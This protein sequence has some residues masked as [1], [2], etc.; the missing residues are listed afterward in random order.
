MRKKIYVYVRVPTKD[1][2]EDRQLI[3]LQ[4]FPVAA[5]N[6]FMDKLSGKNFNHPQYQ[7]LMGRLKPHDVLVVKSIDRLG[8]NYDEILE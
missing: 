2:C 7:K 4:K 5:G 1:Q 8:R 3:A 6:I